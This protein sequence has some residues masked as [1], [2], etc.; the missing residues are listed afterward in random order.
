M[1]HIIII[2]IMALAREG[3]YG[4]VR[5]LVQAQHFLEQTT[6]QAKISYI[7]LRDIRQEMDAIGL[8]QFLIKTSMEYPL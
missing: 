2:E 4:G 5:Y 7:P 1:Y 8:Q 6:V 3:V